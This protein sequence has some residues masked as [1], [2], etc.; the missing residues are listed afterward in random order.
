MEDRLWHRHYDF[1][2]QTEYRHPKFP[3]HELVNLAANILPDKA[4]VNY[5]GA[6]LT[7]HELK[8]KVLA[9]ATMFEKMGIQK[10]DR[11]GLHLPNIPEYVIAFYAAGYVGAVVVNFNPMYTVDELVQLV[12]LTRLEAMI[13]FD[14]GVAVINAVSQQVNIP[15]KIAVSIFDSMGGDMSTPQSMGLDDSWLHFH[16]LIAQCERPC[17]PRVAVDC[18]DP[19]VIQFTGGTTGIPKG[20]V[21][22][23]YNIISTAFSAVHWG[24]G[25]TGYTPVEKRTCM[26]ALPFFHVYGNIIGMNWAMIHCA[27]MYLVPKFEIDPFMDLLTGI[28]HITFFPAVP[29]MISAIVNHPR[30]AELQLDKKIRLVNSGGAPI[31][32]EL[33]EKA[34]DT[35][36]TASEGWGM[37]ETTSLGVANPILGRKKVGSIGIPL[38]GMDVRL[39]DVEDGKTDVMPGE[40]GEMLIKGP[41]VMKEYWENPEQT[42]EEL[43]DGWMHTG[44][45]AK[46][47]EDG[48]L[49]I[50]D[51]KKDM[52]IAGGYNIYPR[53]IDEV[54]YQHP[55][56]AEAVAVGVKDAYRGETIK[57]YVVLR[58]DETAT[59]E[60]I[61][62]FCKEKLAAYKVPK[63]VEFRK[64]L[65]KSAVG[66][67]LRRILR[68]EEEAKG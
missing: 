6:Q 52:V 60:E 9:L 58:P 51:R 19:A 10:G 47:D 56:V 5:Y 8:Q 46:M 66:K 49:F 42:A 59:Q 26:C 43:V 30:A 55:K 68:D 65:P 1:N 4:A 40:P 63:I 11:I 41:F 23:H 53:D 50:V 18:Q 34:L 14:T 67:I 45:V 27:T 21:L 35:G 25:H 61:V 48:Y 29:T 33:M 16:T 22:T 54:L 37:S 36:L 39:V 62:S 38:P 32:H 31:P 44:D 2:V 57:A 3:T 7:F 20:A 13:T 24:L 28:D 15:K 64:E 12:K 17:R